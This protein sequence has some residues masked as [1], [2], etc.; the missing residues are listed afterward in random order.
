MT[1]TEWFEIAS[2]NLRTGGEDTDENV[3]NIVRNFFL[4]ET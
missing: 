2:S 3:R 1:V 4:R